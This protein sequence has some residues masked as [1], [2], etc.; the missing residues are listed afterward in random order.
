VFSFAVGLIGA[1]GATLHV[2]AWIIALVMDILIVSKLD[3]GKTSDAVHYDFWLATFI[4]LVVGLAVVVV[5]T[6]LHALTTMKVPE[7]GMPPFLVTAMTG[8]AIICVIFTYWLMTSSV[9][10]LHKYVAET[11][12]EKQADFAE[13]FRRFALWSLL[14]K[15]YIWQFIYNNQ[16][17][18][19]SGALP[20]A[21]HP[22]PHIA[23]CA[24]TTFT[25]RSEA[26]RL[27]RRENVHAAVRRRSKR[28]HARV[29]RRRRR[30]A[31]GG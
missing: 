28:T 12:A 3:G 25:R 4:P 15:V 30:K 26:S 16:M 10:G 22:R 27:E 11:D 7:G 8:G 18:A 6:L 5:T 24:H 2:A 13:Q 19:A 21:P 14:S 31:R 17:W 1:L 9:A 20:S 29:V 23:T